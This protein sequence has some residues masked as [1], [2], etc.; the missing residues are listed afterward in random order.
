[1][2]MGQ[3]EGEGRRERRQWLLRVSCQSLQRQQVGPSRALAQAVQAD[4]PWRPA[5]GWAGRSGA[6]GFPP[7]QDPE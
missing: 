4:L 3:H 7:G 6:N 1:M 2:D 5:P